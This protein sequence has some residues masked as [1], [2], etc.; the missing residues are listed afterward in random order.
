MQV[1]ERAHFATHIRKHERKYTYKEYAVK[2]NIED[3]LRK[4]ERQW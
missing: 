4:C 3:G 2:E 1:A